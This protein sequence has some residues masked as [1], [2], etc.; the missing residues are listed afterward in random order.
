ME[1]GF[2]K[3]SHYTMFILRPHQSQWF[4]GEFSSQTHLK[5]NK[6][7]LKN[8][9]TL[10]KASWKKNTTKKFTNEI[11]AWTGTRNATWRKLNYFVVLKPTWSNYRP[12]SA[13]SSQPRK[14]P[15]NIWKRRTIN[16]CLFER[17]ETTIAIINILWYTFSRALILIP[18]DQSLN[19][20]WTSKF[21][22]QKNRGQ[23]TLHFKVNNSPS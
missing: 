7:P 11:T 6:Y 17:L 19:L 21:L 4:Y 3:N 5:C 20:H 9:K 1:K 15:V 12:K 16:V 14:G 8:L 13:L 22:G 18:C 10:G 2:S 23:S